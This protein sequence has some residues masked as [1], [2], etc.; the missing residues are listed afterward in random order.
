MRISSND[1]GIVTLPDGTHFALAV[2]TRGGKDG[3]AREAA[4]ASIARA[5]WEAFVPGR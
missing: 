4:I 5:A 1:V 3:A 2:F